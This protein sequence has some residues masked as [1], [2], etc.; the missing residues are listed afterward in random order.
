MKLLCTKRSP[1][2][3]KI[4]VLAIEKQIPLELIE[5]DLVN[6]SGRLTQANPLGK[7]PALIF[8]NGQTL[9]DSPVICEYIDGLKDQ[10]R[11]IPKDKE[12]RF[13]VLHLAAIA[14]GIMDAA[15]AAYMEKLR[16]PDNF[17]E[18][19]IKVQEDAIGRG[20]KFLEQNLTELEKFTL[21]PIAVASAIGYLNFR[22]PQ[23]DPKHQYPKLAKWFEEFSQ[24]PSMM[25]TKPG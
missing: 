21:A 9:I 15:V 14:D 19:F 24:R 16:H 10:P 6:K 23:L 17:H 5:E 4:R 20:F 25:E 12:E 13:K 8:D 7:V 18:A 1:Y 2:A 3:R 22:L 11:F